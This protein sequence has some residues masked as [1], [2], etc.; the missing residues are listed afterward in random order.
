M[1][2]PLIVYLP[3]YVQDAKY[4][5]YAAAE[6]KQAV[7]CRKAYGCSYFAFVPGGW[8]IFDPENDYPEG[9]GENSHFCGSRTPG[10]DFNVCATFPAEWA[11]YLRG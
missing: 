5:F 6:V 11:G 10:G 1:R 9:G 2:I 4:H 8:A 3:T 7:D